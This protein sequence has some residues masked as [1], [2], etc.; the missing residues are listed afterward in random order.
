VAELSVRRAEAGDAE[1][2]S[3]LNA[4]VHAVH[5]AGMPERFRPPGPGTFP[6]PMVCDLLGR[7][8]TLMFL[9]YAGAVPVGY[10][11]AQVMRRPENAIRYAAPM[12]YIH[13]ISVSPDY[14]GQGIGKALLG[15]VRAAVRAAGREAGIGRVE[16]DV[17][18]FNDA[19]R[20]FFRR[21]GFVAVREVLS[22][23]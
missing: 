12:V 3:R 21:Q 17:W 23:E 9:A 7:T 11:Y 22:L 16:L 20:S 2:V 8:D 13:H 18:M 19:A 1:L 4:D 6:P 5:A 10:V 15:A 14:R